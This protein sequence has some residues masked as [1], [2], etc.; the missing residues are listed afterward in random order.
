MVEPARNTVWT[1]VRERREVSH[2][3]VGSQPQLL[4][5]DY[6]DGGATPLFRSPVLSFSRGELVLK[7]HRPMGIRLWGKSW[8]L[9][10]ACILA[11]P[12]RPTVQLVGSSVHTKYTS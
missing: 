3:D 8:H 9:E 12:H 10:I 4:N 6:A 7:K 1:T 11:V 2:T 5:V